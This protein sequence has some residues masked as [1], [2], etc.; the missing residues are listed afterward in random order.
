MPIRTQFFGAV[1]FVIGITT[2]VLAI[3][4][5][6]SKPAEDQLQRLLTQWRDALQT[7]AELARDR[8]L[9]GSS[10]F[11]LV[12]DVEQDL[13]TAN[14]DLATTTA[15]R[16]AALEQMV[17]NR[18]QDEEHE[19][20]CLE[21][22]TGRETAFAAAKVARLKAEITLAK[23][24]GAAVA[25][26]DSRSEPAEGQLQR[27][28]T[29]WRDAL[30]TRVEHLQARYMEGDTDIELVFDTERDLLT[31]NLELATTPSDRI[32]ALEKMTSSMGQREAFQRMR[33]ESG[34][35]SRA[36]LLAA[37]AARLN[38]EITLFN[39]IGA[40]PT[41]RA[42]ASLRR[43]LTERR[44][45]LELRVQ[46]LRSLFESGSANLESVSY[47]KM[48]FLNADLDLAT[49]PAERIAALE[50]MVS[51]MNKVEDLQRIRIEAGIGR[52]AD[53]LE[54]K[55]RRLEAEIG[56]FRVKNPDAAIPGE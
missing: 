3:A 10:N 38:A 44:D 34:S 17:S 18:K 52:E 35:G 7:R 47:A 11:E 50:Q 14:L 4:Q 5:D 36:D 55:T 42:D 2:A 20:M 13:L 16:I 15:D 6:T 43:V 21:I 29:Q 22:G 56:L 24:I 32:V 41:E 46:V 37:K 28:L 30:Q 12:F 25:E 49:T 8:Y 54:A 1:F 48:D 53:F 40:G 9:Q 27:L 23:E 33:F 51:I 45:T 26:S 39:K 31:A 19:R